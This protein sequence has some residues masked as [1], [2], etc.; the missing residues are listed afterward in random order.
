MSENQFE[1][2][3]KHFSQYQGRKVEFKY[4]IPSADKYAKGVGFIHGIGKGCLIINE[5]N[6]THVI[7]HEHVTLI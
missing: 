5:R 7:E 3:T 1:Y 4:Y 2:I 6:W